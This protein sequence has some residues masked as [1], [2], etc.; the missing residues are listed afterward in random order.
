MPSVFFYFLNIILISRLVFAFRDKPVSRKRMII[1]LIIQLA[2]LLVL[3]P[4]WVLL[5]LAVLLAGMA[6]LLHF[7]ENRKV[8]SPK[9]LVTGLYETRLACLA[10]YILMGSI[11]FSRWAGLDF[12][13][14]LAGFFER[15]GGYTLLVGSPLANWPHLHLILFG[16]LL[17]TNEANLIVRLLLQAFRL[18]P[19]VEEKLPQPDQP[20][21]EG[22]IAEKQPPEVDVHEFNAG[23]VIGILERLLIYYFV[24]NAQYSAIGFILAAKS[25]TRFRELEKRTFAEYVLIGTLLSALL[26]ML[27]AGLVQALMP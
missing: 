19:P 5:I 17:V 8:R 13:P 21:D 25:F 18:A 26:A 11:L 12:N 24:L 23:R 27:G 2:G 10:V 4:G 14:G 22:K 16:A 3:R 15:I 7:L 6:V 20:V 1:M 9:D